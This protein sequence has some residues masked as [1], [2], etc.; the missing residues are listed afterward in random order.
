MEYDTQPHA[1]ESAHKI[2]VHHNNTYLRIDTGD[3]R[4]HW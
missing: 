1:L 4:P 2:M 3:V